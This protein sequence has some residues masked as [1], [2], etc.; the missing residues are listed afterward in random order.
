M[1]IKDIL[2]AVMLICFGLSWPISV[3]KNIKLK[4]ARPMNLPFILLIFIGYIAGIFAKILSGNVNWVL[5]VY[6]IN[7]G[8]VS[9]NI[10]VYFYNRSLDKKSGKFGF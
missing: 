10:G 9:T 8:F 2:E 6:F 7:L 5:I 4:S 1:N 3:Y